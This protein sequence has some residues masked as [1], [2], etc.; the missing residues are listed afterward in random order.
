MPLFVN[1]WFVKPQNAF[2]IAQFI[3]YSVENF[4][5]LLKTIIN[6]ICINTWTLHII[7][8]YYDEIYKKTKYNYNCRVKSERF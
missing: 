5:N 2:L 1:L 3:Q 7:Y 8:K 6:I 4:Y